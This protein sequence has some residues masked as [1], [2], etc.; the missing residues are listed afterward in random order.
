MKSPEEIVKIVETPKK[1][2]NS[3]LDFVVSSE[4]KKNGNKS[5][6]QVPRSPKDVPKSPVS[7]SKSSFTPLKTPGSNETKKKVNDAVKPQ[8]EKTSLELQRHQVVENYLNKYYKLERKVFGSNN[9]TITSPSQ[10]SMETSHVNNE[11]LKS[12]GIVPDQDDIQMNTPN[13]GE[14]IK[15]IRRPPKA[16]DFLMTLNKPNLP[17]ENTKRLTKRKTT[18]ENEE[19]DEFNFDENQRVSRLSS[20]NTTVIADDGP[21]ESSGFL[22]KLASIFT[23]VKS[24]DDR[25]PK[26]GE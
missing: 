14:D 12:A 25:K 24:R 5:P 15:L 26:R 18:K 8:G 9:T 3:K 11:E 21:E 7:S 4:K 1:A 2:V 23:C 17:N 13:L 22:Y 6:K 19:K 10:V 20:R 16:E